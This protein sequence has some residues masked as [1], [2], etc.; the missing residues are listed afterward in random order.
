MLE[1][2][3]FDWEDDCNH[4]DHKKLKSKRKQF[5]IQRNLISYRIDH[6][7]SHYSLHQM[8]IGG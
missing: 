8:N 3:Q 5:L 7:L 6:M 4:G 2:Y 1:L